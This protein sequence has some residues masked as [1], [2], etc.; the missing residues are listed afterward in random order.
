[1]LA[2]AACVPATV[3]PP[4]P[5]VAAR[6]APVEPAETAYLSRADG[7]HKLPA[8]PLEKL[9]VE[10]RRQEI[11][12]AS[13]MPPGSIVIHPGQKFLY[14]ITGPGKAIRYGISVGRQGFDWAGD[15]VV[16]QTRNWPTWTPPPEMID[17][18]PKLSKWANGQPGGPTNP[19]GARAIYL[20]SNGRDYGY[21]IHGTPDWWSIGK[22]ASSG[23]I[24]MIHQDVIDL[25]TRV[26][27]GA[28]VL[29]LNAD[30]TRPAKLRVPPPAPVK[31]KPAPEPEAATPAVAESGTS[32]GT[33][34][35]ASLPE[36]PAT[37]A[38]PPAAAVPPSTG[39]T[40]GISAPQNTA[41]GPQAPAAGSSSP[42]SPAS[43][44]AAPDVAARAPTVQPAA[45][46][47]PES[48]QSDA[49]P[50]V[51]PQ[52]EAAGTP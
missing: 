38:T 36:G 39:A 51:I 43:P 45:P 13:D 22:R 44:A 30:G 49:T 4:S 28:Q 8:V 14:F 42:A 31:K 41:P 47:Q 6:M 32:T 33:M 5:E 3:E 27:R 7:P 23:C 18:D 37:T 46:S 11:D 52:S 10:Y 9:P 26:Q 35:P 15:A 29:V 40:T 34:V 16:S 2:L 25:E 12:Y 19:L 17:R 48:A 1:M 20:L 50:V 24:R 21:R